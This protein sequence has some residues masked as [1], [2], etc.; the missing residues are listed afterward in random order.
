MLS[1]LSQVW[2]LMCKTGKLGLSDSCGLVNDYTKR[3]HQGQLIRLVQ[4]SGI[5]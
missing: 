1:W 5:S 4:Q 3:I 2:A